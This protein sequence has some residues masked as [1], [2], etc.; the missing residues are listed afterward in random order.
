MLYV[1]AAEIQK[2]FKNMRTTFNK[3]VAKVDG[4]TQ[5]GAGGV[6]DDDVTWPYYHAMLFLKDPCNEPSRSESNL[7]MPEVN[8]YFFNS[9]CLSVY[10][11]FLME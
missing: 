7:I 11:T 10:G 4:P 9:Q 1:S 5:S 6:S 3:V 2:K 8:F